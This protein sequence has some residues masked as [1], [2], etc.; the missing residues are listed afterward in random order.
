MAERVRFIVAELGE[1][2]DPFILHL[3]AALAEH[4]C[5]CDFTSRARMKSV[6]NW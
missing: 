1:A 2:N 5:G 4:S 6:E 3:F